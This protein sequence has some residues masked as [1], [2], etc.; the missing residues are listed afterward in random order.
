MSNLFCFCGYDSFL[1]LILIIFC[2][3]IWCSK[4][5]YILF[6]YHFI[7]NILCDR[8][9]SRHKTLLWHKE[10]K[11]LFDLQAELAAIFTEE[12]FFYLK[13]QL[14]DF[15]IWQAFSQKKD[16]NDSVTSKENN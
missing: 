12:Q 10:E 6:K 2:G 3:I 8:K 9:E 4:F 7:F 5:L 11:Q 14:T 15:G 16:P 1:V 13:E